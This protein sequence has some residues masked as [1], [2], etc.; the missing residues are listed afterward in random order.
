LEED[1]EPTQPSALDNEFRT[2]PTVQDPTGQQQMSPPTDDG[3]LFGDA[4]ERRTK[5]VGYY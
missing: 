5:K 4:P 1:G 3:V 2:I